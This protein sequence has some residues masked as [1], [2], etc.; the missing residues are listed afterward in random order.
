M[1]DP[2]AYTTQVVYDR[3]SPQLKLIEVYGAPESFTTEISVFTTAL[4]S[5]K[6]RRV[7]APGSEGGY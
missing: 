3:Y 5:Q 4:V 7:S 2:A 6:N 1:R